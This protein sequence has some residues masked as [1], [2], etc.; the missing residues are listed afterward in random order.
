[1]FLICCGF[2]FKFILFN[3]G[4]LPFD[5]ADLEAVLVVRNRKPVYIHGFVYVSPICHK[6]QVIAVIL[7][8]LEPFCHLEA[9]SAFK[10]LAV[11]EVLI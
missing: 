3:P 2:F 9:C 8:Y 6:M 10:L 4:D 7:L 1:M 5:K 11:F